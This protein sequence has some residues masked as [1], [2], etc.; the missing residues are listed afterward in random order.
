[1]RARISAGE[2]TFAVGG[3]G[4]SDF[5][6]SVCTGAVGTDFGR[7]GCALALPVSATQIKNRKV[8]VSIENL[9]PFTAPQLQSS[10]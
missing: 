10:I 9:L 2:A 4:A 7:G 8:F 1:M 6:F 5:D 3:R